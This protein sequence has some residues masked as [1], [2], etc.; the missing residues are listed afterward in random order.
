MKNDFFSSGEPGSFG[1]N[2]IAGRQ[3]AQDGEEIEQIVR[4]ILQRQ[5]G[6][7]REQALFS[8]PAGKSSGSQED[9]VASIDCSG[10]GIPTGGLAPV[11]LDFSQQGQTHQS[12]G[13][14]RIVLESCQ[15]M[16]F[17]P[18]RVPVGQPDP[19]RSSGQAEGFG[20]GKSLSLGTNP[21]LQIGPNPLPQSP[22][23]PDAEPG[24][25]GGQSNESQEQDSDPP[26]GPEIALGSRDAGGNE[27][28]TQAQQQPPVLLIVR[29][30]EMLKEKFLRWD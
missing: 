15:E 2:R 8:R 7:A 26:P 1:P 19:S 20:P 13:R 6:P 25:S 30:G 12:I 4:A 24:L 17:F 21:V 23:R 27:V 18:R 5:L 16:V 9:G 14:A 28:G 10:P 3:R 11:P 29:G 22:N